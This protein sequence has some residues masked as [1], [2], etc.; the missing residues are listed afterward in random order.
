MDQRKSGGNRGVEFMGWVL[1]LSV[2]VWWLLAPFIHTYGYSTHTNYIQPMEG[3][4]RRG[5]SRTG[6]FVFRKWQRPRN[7]QGAQEL[8]VN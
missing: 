2:G 5:G 8:T 3:R 1:S 4:L 6:T 7:S